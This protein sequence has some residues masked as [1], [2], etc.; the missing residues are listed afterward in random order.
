MITTSKR[1]SRATPIRRVLA[2]CRV[3]FGLMP[4]TAATAVMS[5]ARPSHA[6]QLMTKTAY[7]LSRRGSGDFILASTSV[8]IYG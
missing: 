7:P 6:N 3:P 5:T 1:T 2:T 4:V 8:R